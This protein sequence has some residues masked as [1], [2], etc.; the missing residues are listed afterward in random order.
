M[1]DQSN[2]GRKVTEITSHNTIILDMKQ[3][4]ST[5]NAYDKIRLVTEKKRFFIPIRY[6]Q[7]QITLPTITGFSSVPDF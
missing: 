5:T 2:D 1:I 3:Y 4:R 6:G 7:I